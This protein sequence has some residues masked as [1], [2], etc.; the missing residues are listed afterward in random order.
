M[1]HQS[2]VPVSW[3]AS[4]PSKIR[5]THRRCRGRRIAGDSLLPLKFP[6]HRSTVFSAAD[7]DADFRSISTRYLFWNSA[8]SAGGVAIASGH[9]LI[10]GSPVYITVKFTHMPLVRGHGADCSHTII[11]DICSTA[12]PLTSYGTSPQ[13]S[14]RLLYLSRRAFTCASRASRFAPPPCLEIPLI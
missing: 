1:Q 5:W 10:T 14:Y 11:D 6:A 13:P 12:P 4:S 9:I 3:H 7:V 8:T 2:K